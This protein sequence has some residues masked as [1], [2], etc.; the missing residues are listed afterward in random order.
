MAITDPNAIRYSN[1]IARPSADRLGKRYYSGKAISDRW[2]ALGGGQ[3]ATDALRD[4]IHEWCKESYADYLFWYDANRRWVAYGQTLIPDTP[5]DDPIDDGSPE[6][7]RPASTNSKI[8]N[9]V[10]RLAESL[11]DWDAA[12]FAKLNTVL[13]VIEAPASSLSSGDAGNAINRMTEI[14]TDLEANSNA[15]LNTILAL[16]VNPTSN[17]VVPGA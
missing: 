7:G 12:S 1:E 13:A 10:T 15:K 9:V 14:A 3:A 5:A 11:T 17:I 2:T 16:A 4:V 6:D 8:R